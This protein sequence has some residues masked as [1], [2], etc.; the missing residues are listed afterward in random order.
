VPTNQKENTM[1]DVPPEPDASPNTDPDPDVVPSS[2]PDR[3]GDDPETV[4]DPG[5]DAV[6]TEPS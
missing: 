5:S 1:T 3:T 4:I 6:G 2:E